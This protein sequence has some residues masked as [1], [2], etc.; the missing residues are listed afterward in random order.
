MMNYV[1]FGVLLLVVGGG[2]RPS[3]AAADVFCDNLK[4]VAA[5]L[6]QN[7]SSSPVQ[8]ATAIVGQ[9]PD[10]VYALAFCQGDYN[11][12]ACRECVAQAFNVTPACNK[13]GIFSYKACPVLYAGDNFIDPS[14]ATEQADDTPF[15]RWNINNV[16][17]DADDVRLITGLIRELLVDTVDRAA[18]TA[19]R[20]FA[21][22]V[23]DSG[24]P[25]PTMY[26]MAQ[27]TPDLSAS[28]CLACLRRLVGMVNSTMALRMGAQIHV[29]RCY[30]RY[31]AYSLYDSQPM[32]RVGPPSVPA[33]APAP[34]IGARRKSKLWVIPVVVVPLAVAAAAALCFIFYSPWFR[35]YRKGETT[36]AKAG[37]QELQG[38]LVLDG[39]NSEFRVFDFEQGQF[40]DGLE[41]AVKRLASHSGQGFT[42]FKNEVQL[43]AKLQHSNLV[44]LLGCCS[45]EEEKIL[46]YEYLPNKSLDSF[47]FDENKRALL[48]WSRLL[49]IIEGIA[50]GLNYLH[51]HSR[52]RVIHRDLKPSNILLDREMNPKISDFGLAKIFSSNNI[53]GNTTRRVVGTYG[54][55]APEYASEGIFSVKSDV[56]SFGVLVLEIITG[57]RNSGSHQCGDFINLIG[58]SQLGI[59]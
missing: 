9:A 43:I 35:R 24:R 48:D 52:L 25:F 44:R 31:E 2:L 10:V 3:P 1:I 30:F 33:P 29:I 41:V 42:E 53:G 7:T 15:V 54:Y 51:K 14:N 26:S 13:D 27:C 4:Q 46:V 32:L 45:Q 21:T 57:K 17:G 58:Y 5:T 50:H 56:F 8:F 40:A 6:P 34:A 38:E 11:A 39:K 47:I 22:G 28:D 16:T 36:M 23:M 19:P 55:M 37:S 12:T 18:S 49:S 59:P 20:R